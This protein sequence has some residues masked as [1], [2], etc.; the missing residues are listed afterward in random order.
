MELSLTSWDKV[1]R[2]V[3][4]TASFVV[5]SL[6]GDLELS[7]QDGIIGG[8]ITSEGEIPLKQDITKN[9]GYMQ[10]V[11]VNDLEDNEIGILLGSRFLRHFAGKEIRKGDVDEPIAI[12]T[13]LGWA[14]AG[15]IPDV[16]N[17]NL[18]IA[19]MGVSEID[20]KNIDKMIREMFRHDFINRPDEN[21]PSEVTHNSQFD[22][23][24]LE[25]IRETVKFVLGNL[26]NPFKS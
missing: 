3:K 13:D 19:Q 17:Y 15:P 26:F 11:V 6:K 5:Q 4:P 1:E 2:G 23:Y 8:I 16:D 20:L 10:D 9:F 24:S 18:E 14:I 7:I 22:E 25:Q 12:N 21:F